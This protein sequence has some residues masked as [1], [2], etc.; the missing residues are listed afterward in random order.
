MADRDAAPPSEIFKLISGIAADGARP[1]QKRFALERLA[2]V[3][4]RLL[5]LLML[6]DDESTDDIIET[7]LVDV[8]YVRGQINA[9]R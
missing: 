2:L 1:H 8:Q 7:L 4:T 5:S 6:S 3:Q 9:I